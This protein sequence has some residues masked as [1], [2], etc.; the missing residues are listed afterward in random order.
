MYFGTY[1]SLSLN[2]LSEYA[3]INHNQSVVLR[4]SNQ[5]ESLTF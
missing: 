3:P 4:I 2:E 1:G 5:L